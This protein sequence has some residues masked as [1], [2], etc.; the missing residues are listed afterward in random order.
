MKKPKSRPRIGKSG[1]PVSLARLQMTGGP[2]RGVRI[3]GRIT[4]ARWSASQGVGAV[5]AGPFSPV[6]TE[7][8]RPPCGEA[9][10]FPRLQGL[11]INPTTR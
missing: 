1:F 8:M 3:G 7:P 11:L 4:W 6:Y 5:R 10:V 2:V 9:G